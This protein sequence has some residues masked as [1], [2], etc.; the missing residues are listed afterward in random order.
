MTT[1]GER[2]LVA[3]MT[4]RSFVKR[5]GGGLALA[6]LTVACGPSPRPAPQS[7][8]PTTVAPAQARR[9]GTLV[10]GSSRSIATTLPY[11]GNQFLFSW[12]GPFNPLVGLDTKSQPTPALAESWTLSDDRRSLRLKL[13]QGVTFH[14]G[15]KFTADEARWNIEYVKDPK[16]QAAAGGELKNVEVGVL[17]AG[18]LDLRLPDLMPH[19]FSL[20]AGVLMV[21]PQSDLASNAAGTGP[22]K[23]ESLSPG[24]ELRLIRN[25]RYWRP[26]RPY[27][28]GVTFR[29]LTDPS[30]AAIAL[31]SGAAGLVQ[32]A[33]T[34]V[35][36]L[37]T[38]G[39]T[40]VVIL[41]DSGSYDFAL[42]AAEPPF[43]DRRVRQAI[44]LA[45]DRKRFAD[46][47]MYGLTDPTHIIWL[48]SS[49]A[50]NASTD[51]GEFNLD[52]AR[53]LL[54]DAGYANGFETKIQCNPT[55][56]E[57]LQFDQI[58]Q[59]DLAT[60]GVHATIE[61]LDLNQ[62]ATLVTQAK[63]PAIINHSY[64][65]GDQ[66][67]AMQFTAFVLR[68]EANASR[69]QSDEYVRRVEAARR[70]L[71][72][73]KRMGLYHDIARF[74]KEEAFLLPVANRIVPWGVRANV[75]G[76]SRQPLQG[77]P[78]LEDLWVA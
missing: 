63:F 47:V 30:S 22:F 39:Q 19:I 48:K 6:G 24:D 4:R 34:D 7:V 37:N 76:I 10:I 64:A 59:A 73:D 27:L 60:I 57:M 25:E 61:Q 65:Y 14:S 28:D 55:L 2:V 53:Q 51:V 69:F 32:L 66:D 29:T 54:I 31:E 49:P 33:I 77:N 26:D 68:P 78:V 18:T 41:P 16:N 35:K 75:H 40:S 21:D 44:D 56:A 71:D 3:S 74:V 70:E 5:L 20:L 23:V 50:W 46:T 58:V 67:P 9:G 72:W 1:S 62:A 12:G 42:N 11:P 43:N 38:G 45:L 8:A 52:R 36:R 17:D 13:R 15:R